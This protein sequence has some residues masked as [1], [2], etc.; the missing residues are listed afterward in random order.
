MYNFY[1]ELNYENLTKEEINKLFQ[2]RNDLNVRNYLIKNNLKLVI[3]V[4]KKYKSETIELDD[5]INTGSIGL[6][7]AV[8]TFDISKD[9]CF[10]TYAI[11]CINN[12]VLMYLRKNNKIDISLDEE[13]EPDG[14]E[15]LELIADPKV[16]IEESYINKQNACVIEKLLDTL[17]ERN[18]YILKLYYGFYNGKCYTQQEIADMLNISQVNVSRI[19]NQSLTKFKTNTKSKKLLMTLY[20]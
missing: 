10:S 14:N 17:T 3:K 13:L 15:L 18:K 7:K 5:L 20:P 9:I 4:V 19:I 8:D 6:I 1:S 16:D 2:N 12:E 11:R